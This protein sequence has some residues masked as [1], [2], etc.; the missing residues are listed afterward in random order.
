[1]TIRSCAAQTTSSQN[2]TATRAAKSK[3]TAPFARFPTKPLAVPSPKKAP[4]ATAIS[5]NASTARSRPKNAAPA[6][7]AK[8]PTA[9]RSASRPKSSA[10][11]SHQ[12]GN[13]KTTAKRSSIAKA[14]SSSAKRAI[15]NALPPTASSINASKNALP[16]SK[17]WAKPENAKITASRIA[18]TNTG[19]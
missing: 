17:L 14:G 10:A 19:R 1:M 2:T 5:S 12:T 7:N 4:A 8:L 15:P 6:P 16:S 3:K 11:T 13:A 9:C 18:A